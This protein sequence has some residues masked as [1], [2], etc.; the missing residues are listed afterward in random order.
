MLHSYSTKIKILFGF[1]EQNNEIQCL[2]K[3]CKLVI[4]VG[5]KGITKKRP[6]A[7][8]IPS[9]LPVLLKPCLND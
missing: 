9:S 7:A 2:A 6:T 8:S 3:N 1:L 4:H 5:D